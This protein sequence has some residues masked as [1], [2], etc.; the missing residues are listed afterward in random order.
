MIAP[1]QFALSLAILL[2]AAQWPRRLNSPCYLRRPGR[3]LL[4]GKEVDAIYGDY[5]LRNDKLVVVIAQPLA[6]AQREHDRPQRGRLHYRFNG[7]TRPERS[8]QCLLPCRRYPMTAPTAVRLTI[9]GQPAGALPAQ[10]TSGGTIALEVDAD[11]GEKKPQLTVR[12]VLAEHSPYLVVETI[13]RNSADQAVSDELS[14]AIR[15]DRT[16][17]FQF[18]PQTHC[19]FA[20]DE[21]FRQAYGV[22]ADGYEIKGTGQRGTLLQLVKDGTNKLTLQPVHRTR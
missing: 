9:D 2:L 14:D 19:F 12:Y 17:T 4:R 16:F 20:D 18:D 1:R 8:A 15:A 5:V 10:P 7:A 13:F 3:R 22:V 21:W 6:T 11:R